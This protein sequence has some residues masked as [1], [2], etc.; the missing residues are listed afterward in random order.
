MIPTQSDLD[1]IV[2][3]IT[4]LVDTTTIYLFGS[5]AK[6]SAHLG[7]DIDLFIVGPS[8]LPPWRRGTEVRAALTA[9]PAHFDLLFYTEAELANECRDPLSFA[10]R[11]LTSARIL[12]Q[13][14]HKAF[15]T[16]T[17]AGVGE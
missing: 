15:P 9:F 13:R 12:Y 8:R 2:D 11:I 1:W 4:T 16:E 14:P 17:R 10:A 6:G 7:S 3:R 5:R